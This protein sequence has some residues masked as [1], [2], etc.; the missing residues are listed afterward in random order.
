MNYNFSQQTKTTARVR[1]LFVV[2]LVVGCAFGMVTHA[3]AQKIVSPTTPT[4]ITPPAGNSSFMVGHALGTQG[5]VCLPMST[6]A[7]WTVNNAR[8][9]ATLFTKVFGQDFEIIT[10]FP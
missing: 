5:Y 2:A 4:G 8:P 6:G 1:N 7:S 10:H 3:A 9:E